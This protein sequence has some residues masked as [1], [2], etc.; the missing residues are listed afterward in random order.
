MEQG[1]RARYAPPISERHMIDLAAPLVGIAGR[2]A[3]PAM[4]ID[5]ADLA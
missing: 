1:R 2:R 3:S 4:A 5:L